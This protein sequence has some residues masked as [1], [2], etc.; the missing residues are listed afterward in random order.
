MLSLHSH[1]HSTENT[2]STISAL[3]FAS[4]RNFLVANDT[5]QNNHFR[6][7]MGPMHL[8]T[9]LTGQQKKLALW[10]TQVRG[11]KAF[12]IV[13]LSPWLLCNGGLNL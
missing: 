5:K 2:I 3:V 10:T 7:M 13:C 1:S 4:V 6:A 11:Q 12:R 8:C 9:N